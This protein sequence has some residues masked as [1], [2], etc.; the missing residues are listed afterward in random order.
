MPPPDPRSRLV[1]VSPHSEDHTAVRQTL[2]R[3]VTA[4]EGLNFLFKHPSEQDRT[5]DPH[6]EV[7]MNTELRISPRLPE[8]TIL[9]T[10]DEPAIVQLVGTV[11]KAEGYRVLTARSPFEALRLAQRHP[12]AVDLLLSDIE[13]HTMDG[14]VLWREV[15]RWH[16]E[17]KVILMSGSAGLTSVPCVPFLNKPFAMSQ[18]TT[19]VR[20]V[21][22]SECCF[23]HRRLQGA[24]ETSH[25]KLVVYPS[26][27]LDLGPRGMS[28]PKE[29]K[30]WLQ[31][32]GPDD[33]A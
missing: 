27:G 10:D 18:L 26:E 22:H 5:Q 8:P 32:E 30:H 19:K 25:G 2:R 6:S 17:A 3:P 7:R 28:S 15:K 9:V 14:T 23:S 12:V 11:L 31:E 21:L 33:A 13:M 20:T 24:L 16:P 1:L 4:R 29:T